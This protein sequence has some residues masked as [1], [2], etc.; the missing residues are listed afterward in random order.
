M[1]QTMMRTRW[2]CTLH[3][4]SVLLGIAHNGRVEIKFG[5]RFYLASGIVCAACPRC[6]AQHILDMTIEHVHEPVG[7]QE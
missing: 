7:V 2:E 3:E 5:D 4:P 6:G 1:N